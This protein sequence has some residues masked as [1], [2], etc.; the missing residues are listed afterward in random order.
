MSRVS[1]RESWEEVHVGSESEL[2][3]VTDPID[4]HE[5]ESEK[6][7][8]RIEKLRQECDELCYSI[9]RNGSTLDAQHRLLSLKE[10][11]NEARDMKL[12]YSGKIKSRA[13]KLSSR[14][15]EI[16]HVFNLVRKSE[17][18][19]LAFLIDC[20]GS[21]RPYIEGVKDQIVEMVTRIQA[22]CP[23][24]EL[25]VAFVGYRDLMNSSEHFTILQFTSE[26]DE[27]YEFVA[28]TKPIGN[29]DTCEDVAGGL[30]HAVQLE[31]KLPTKVLVHVAESPC[32][33]AEYYNIGTESDEYPAGV[34]IDI[35]GVLAELD[36]MEIQYSFLRINGSTDM[37]ITKFNEHVGR[38]Y[39]RTQQ[40]HDAKGLTRLVVTTVRSSVSSTLSGLMEGDREKELDL[41]PK[42]PEW[43]SI[44]PILVKPIGYKTMTELS[45]I[46]SPMEFYRHKKEYKVQIAPN[47]F[48]QGRLRAARYGRM[49]NNRVVV[50][51]EFK[52]R[53]AVGDLMK[54]Y[55]D[56]LDVS[57]VAE[58]LASMFNKVAKDPS[59]PGIRF[60]TPQ[61]I[62]LGETVSKDSP[63]SSYYFLETVLEGKFTKW[64]NNLD[65]WDEEV[66]SE[67]LLNFC[68]WTHQISN[69]YLMVADLQGVQTDNEFLLTDPVV[70]CKDVTRFG[71]T[72]LGEDAMKR[73]LAAVE[74]FLE[75]FTY[76]LL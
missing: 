15:Q 52:A 76:D 30:E 10:D 47:P 18:V 14:T 53:M 29:W 72:N 67:C 42:I 39:I 50:L 23:D 32:H 35:P 19:D 17:Q 2:V 70:L 31:W 7:E 61:V 58:M 74:E 48:A 24:L 1:T 4:E 38:K 12:S 21:M 65:Y 57:V 34:G 8:R 59:W 60:I 43:N 49:E 3:Y 36:Y 22:T 11:L 64:C 6:L 33:G 26:L 66:L 25:R 40:L 44:D 63:M 13:A 51:K 56:N 73:C 28:D 69:G 75:D 55:L 68:R 46:Y 45:Q 16:N 71:S 9:Y 62:Q 20:T 41:D 37:M 54:T 27:F 5:G